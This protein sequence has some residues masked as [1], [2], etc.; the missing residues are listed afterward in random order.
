[1]FRLVKH[2]QIDRHYNAVCVRLSVRLW[3]TCL[4][5]NPPRQKKSCD[6]ELLRLHSPPCNTA[7]FLSG[8]LQIRAV[9]YFLLSVTTKLPEEQHWLPSGNFAIILIPTDFIYTV[10]LFV[11]H[12]SFSFALQDHSLAFLPL[13]A[14]WLTKLYYECISRIQDYLFPFCAG[15]R[16]I[17]SSAFENNFEGQT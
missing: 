4:C 6:G 7:A 1:M 2:R 3:R 5:Q 15:S 8:H 17:K 14:V 13:S 16:Q 10:L 12:F 11:Q 9:V